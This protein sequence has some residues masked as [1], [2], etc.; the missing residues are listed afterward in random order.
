MS[1]IS[2]GPRGPAVRAFWLSAI[3]APSAVVRMGCSLSSGMFC[4]DLLVN[5]REKLSRQ[6]HGCLR[7]F[8]VR[9]KAGYFRIGRSPVLPTFAPRCQYR[10]KEVLLS[11]TFF[12]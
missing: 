5:F 12:L 11:K 9:E 6:R 3:G 4:F 7:A 10:T 1:C 8:R 2:R